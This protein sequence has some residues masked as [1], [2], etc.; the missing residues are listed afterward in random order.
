MTEQYKFSFVRD[1]NESRMYRTRQQ[2]EAAHPG[3]MA[4]FMYMDFLTMYLFWLTPET[5]KLATRYAK[6]TVIYK[7]F[8][9]PRQGAPDLYQSIYANTQH[10]NNIDERA[11]I[12]ALVRLSKG[13]DIQSP[14]IFFMRLERQLGIRDG[15]YKNMRRLIVEWHKTTKEQRRLVIT[16]LLQYYR[17]NAIKAELFDTLY[18][19]SK[20]NNLEISGARNAERTSIKPFGR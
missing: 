19:Y 3:D 14:M 20:N 4:L 10:E 18:K 2:I 6:D 15:G 9:G 16:R 8:S 7:S 11:V 12:T 13:E 5:K 17:E 1:L